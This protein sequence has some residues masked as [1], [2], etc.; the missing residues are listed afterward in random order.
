MAHHLEPYLFEP[1][2]TNEELESVCEKLRNEHDRQ[3][4]GCTEPSEVRSGHNRW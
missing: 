4:Q 1:L 2:M 3:E